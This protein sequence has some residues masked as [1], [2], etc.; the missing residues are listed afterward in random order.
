MIP[1]SQSRPVQP[2]D[3]SIQTSPISM[4]FP[5]VIDGEINDHNLSFLQKDKEWLSNQLRAFSVNDIQDVLFAQMDGQG[6]LH[7]INKNKQVTTPK[8]F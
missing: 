8:I 4:A 5:L 3:L 7:V 6:N 2:S 1:K